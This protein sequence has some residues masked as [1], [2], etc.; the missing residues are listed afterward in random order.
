MGTD[1]SALVVDG[2]TMLDRA[3]DALRGAGANPL[4]V[5]GRPDVAS[6]DVQAV[7]DHYEAGGP[8]AGIVSTWEQSLA[9][10]LM[11]DGAVVLSCD[12]PRIGASLVAALMAEA[13]NHAH[14]C[15][16]H[17]G[18]AAQPLVAVYRRSALAEMAAA[19]HA[20][21]RSVRRLFPSWSMGIVEASNYAV[22]ADVPDD[23]RG[24]AVVWPTGHEHP[25][26]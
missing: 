23:L 15:L 14:G 6:P 1:K 12:L 17:D 20:G 7:P 5:S 21:E 18:D 3:L 11:I 22:D 24:H 10:N 19:W 4:F 16:A 25:P 9:A 26:R 2:A 8:L 13:A